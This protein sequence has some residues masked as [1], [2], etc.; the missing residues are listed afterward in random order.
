MLCES[1][2]S[3]LGN[4]SSRIVKNII[5]CDPF[6]D[7]HDENGSVQWLR[8]S[9]KVFSNTSIASNEQDAL[10]DR[11]VRT[12]CYTFMKYLMTQKYNCEYNNVY[13]STKNSGLTWDIEF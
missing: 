8:N 3:T 6:N 12:T 11:F 4:T 10:M 2:Y 9:I 7:S 13:I 1:L 5:G